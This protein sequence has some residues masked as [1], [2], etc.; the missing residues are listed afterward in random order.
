MGDL[1]NLRNCIIED[2][3]G[4]TKFG[5]RL[6]R[7]AVVGSI[8]LET[9]LVGAMLMWPLI[10][11]GVLPQ[12]VTVTPLPPYRS[13]Q[14]PHVARPHSGASRPPVAISAV[15]LPPFVT[16]PPSA[17]VARGEIPD[18]SEI[19]IGGPQPGIPGGNE[20]GAPIEIPRPEAPAV[21][22]HIGGAV[23]EAKLVHRVEPEY[24]VPARFLHISGTVELRARIGTD[25]SVRE[26]EV[27]SGNPILA[28]A[29]RDAVQQ[30]R[31]QP[32]RL[33]GQAVEVETYI[34]VNFVMQ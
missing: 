10:T 4:A 19:G 6:R 23:M 28:K 29:A 14:S 24:P 15:F 9:T 20:R 27:V 32:T 16:Q 13:V 31:Y 22:V 34:T 2:D 33:N 11:P 5:R 30:W 3:A 18:P 7:K 25:G 17:A 21:P 8:F 12:R 26:L 1:G